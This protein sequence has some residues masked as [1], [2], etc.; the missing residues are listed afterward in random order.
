MCQKGQK[1]EWFGGF[2]V[3]FQ[4]DREICQKGKKG[5]KRDK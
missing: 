3:L 5:A 1:E 2:L 4:E